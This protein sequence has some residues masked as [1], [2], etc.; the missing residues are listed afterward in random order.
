MSAFAKS[1][2]HCTVEGG[3]DDETSAFRFVPTCDQDAPFLAIAVFNPEL[4][5][6]Q[7]G[8]M[9][10]HPFGIGSAVT[11]YNHRPELIVHTMRTYLAVLM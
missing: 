5:R 9:W 6:I 8:M 4:G 3:V 2:P 11:N 7:F 10:G 1:H